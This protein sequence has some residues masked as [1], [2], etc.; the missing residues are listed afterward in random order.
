MWDPRILGAAHLM[1][2]G[3][4]GL[5]DDQGSSLPYHKDGSLGHLSKLSLQ[6]LLA[7]ALLSLFSLINVIASWLL[8][9]WT[10]LTLVLSKQILHHARH[11][12]RCP[13]PTVVGYNWACMLN[14]PALTPALK[15]GR[16]SGC[17]RRPDANAVS[18]L[19]LPPQE[20]G[21]EKLS[22]L[23]GDSACNILAGLM[24]CS[25]RHLRQICLI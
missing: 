8:A 15:T 21:H 9:N 19:V 22:T 17:G 11:N 18:D 25:A 23:Q 7:L 5:H 20:Q 1:A 10:S 12:L 3:Q 24:I 6:V 13:Q 14:S 16:Q 4:S 2:K